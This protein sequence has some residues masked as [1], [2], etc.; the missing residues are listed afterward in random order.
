MSTLDRKIDFAV[1][2]S[3]KKANPNGDPLN[4]NMPRVNYDGFGEVSDVCLKR[5]IRNRLQDM[6]EKIF[7]QSDDKNV[8]GYKS[9]Q[10][11]AKA[12]EKLKGEKDRTKYKKVACEE[13]IDVRAFGQVFAFKGD[14]LSVGVRGP[15]TVQ[16]AES[17]D[18]IVPSSMQITK[19]VNSVT[20]ERKSSDTMGTKHRVDFG[21]Y[22][23]FGSINVQLAEDTGFTYDDAMKIKEALKTLFENDCSSARPEGSMAIEKMV[24]WEH[25]C[26]IGQYPSAAVHRTVNVKSLVDD[27]KSMNDYKI[28]VDD[29]Q[30]LSREE[31]NG[32]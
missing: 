30:G 17:V 4:G 20:E 21:V 22:K 2:F 10:D 16:T 3:V 25:N 32:I 29:L 13:W 12:C 11:R 7:V 31:Y 27:P 19:S 9:L 28:E 15:V 24:W 26:K 8:D 1:V 6:G 23:F 5:K 18:R 14:T